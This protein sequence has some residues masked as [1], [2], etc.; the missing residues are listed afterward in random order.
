MR[1]NLPDKNYFLNKT[2]PLRPAIRILSHKGTGANAHVFRGHS[3]ELGRDL[4]CKII[5]RKN[6]VGTD[7]DPPTWRTEVLKANRLRS[8]AVVKFSDNTPIGS[9]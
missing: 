1:Q 9:T 5:P 8:G 3:D 4:A 2:L 6:L 7:V